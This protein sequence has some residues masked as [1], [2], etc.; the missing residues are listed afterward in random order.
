[1]TETARTD[2]V[3]NPSP[4]FVRNVRIGLVAF[5]VVVLLLLF[6]V[7]RVPPPTPTLASPSEAFI[8]HVRAGREKKIVSISSTNGSVTFSLGGSGAIAYRASK[9]ALNREMQLVAVH[10]AADAEVG[11]EV[12]AV[13]VLQVPA[14]RVVAPQHEVTAPVP[15]R[16][17]LPRREVVLVRDL[18]PAERDGEREASRHPANLEHVLKRWATTPA[19]HVH[20]RDFPRMRGVM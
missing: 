20:C 9:A 11:A 19:D 10:G 8:D 3:A 15:Q 1:M 2:S 13:R 6:A 12:R 14:A 4:R 7:P 5:V 16:G 17:D 18:E